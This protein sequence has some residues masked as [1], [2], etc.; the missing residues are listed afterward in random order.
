MTERFSSEP[1][2]RD[3]LERIARTFVSVLVVADRADDAR[4]LVAW[5]CERRAADRMHVILATTDAV[6][7]APTPGGVF[8]IG[9]T[10]ELTRARI[11]RSA[12]RQDPDVVAVEDLAVEPEA[13]EV[14]AMASQTG[15]AVM[16]SVSAPSAREAIAAIERALL[17]GARTRG[18]LPQEMVRAILA[19]A[20]PL[21]VRVDAKGAIETIDEVALEEGLVQLHGLVASGKRTALPSARL[22]KL[23]AEQTARVEA[24]KPPAPPELEALHAAMRELYREH[25]R[26]TW[27]PEVGRIDGRLDERDGSRFGGKPVLAPGEEWPRCA[28]GE[29]MLLALQLRLADLPEKARAHVIV[30]EGATHLQLFYCTASPCAVQDAWL[31]F[32]MNRLVRFLGGPLEVPSETPP[33]PD[34]EKFEARSI[35]GWRELLDVPHPEERSALG[36]APEDAEEP[37]ALDRWLFPRAGDKLLGWPW[38]AQAA[39]YPSCRRC[40]EKMRSLFQVSSGEEDAWTKAHLPMLFAADGTGHVTQCPAHPDELGF[41]WA[42]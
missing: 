40:G 10:S 41:G 30:P 13:I 24:M 32:A 38:W 19:F 22:D 14:Y 28:C 29:P 21:V 6:E 39:E 36:G 26:P 5:L 17:E 1:A 8:R 31:P 11:L 23:D 3:L 20:A 27:A 35:T 12:L 25:V 7:T 2:V 33:I 15:H 37:H 4:P 18:D 42:C 9:I 16:A 34:S